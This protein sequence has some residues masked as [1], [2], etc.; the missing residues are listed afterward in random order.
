M[1]IHRIVYLLFFFSFIGF[2]QVGINTTNP[3]PSS[4]LDISS[5]NK[6]LLVPRVALTDPTDQATILSPAKGL[7]VF[8]T[9]EDTNMPEGFYYW[10]ETEWVQLINNLSGSWLLDGNTISDAA[11]AIGT[12]N[13]M[14]LL[15]KVNDAIVGNFDPTGGISIGF[16]ATADEQNGLAIGRQANANSINNIAMGRGSQ[17][18]GSNSF[19]L[20][21]YS[22][23][24]GEYGTAVGTNA[25]ANGL[26]SSAFGHLATATGNE[27]VAIGGGSKAEQLSAVALGAYSEA[28]AIKAFALGPNTKAS[29]ENAFALGV[30]AVAD[31]PNTVVIGEVKTGTVDITP[32]NV[33]IGTKNPSARLDVHGQFK[34]GER[35]SV[36]KGIS[37]FNRTVAT[38]TTIGA[39]GSTIVPFTIPAANVPGSTQAIINYTLGASSNDG[40]AISWAKFNGTSTVR[41][42]FRNES[43]SQINL[44]GVTVHFT[45]TE[46]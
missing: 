30:G 15:L 39:N 3:D 4:I 16:N 40:I 33:G 32:V 22:R 26:N 14:P 25:G 31:V 12:N 34:L 37:G 18:T 45:I 6:G 1:K 27:T 19:A 42:K 24:N 38:S 8:K 43:S 41:V 36:L 9:G 20:G 17:A 11:Q 46:Y 5:S 13:N 23:A 2:A 10:D 21:T 29:A 35:G 44:N 28:T 7:L